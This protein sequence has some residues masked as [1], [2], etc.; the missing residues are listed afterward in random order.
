M[1]TFQRFGVG[2]GSTI[3]LAI[4]AIIYWEV[5]MPIFD[6]VA[7]DGIF[8]WVAVWID[9]IVPVLIVMLLLTVWLWVLAGGVQEE[10]T[11]RRRR[12]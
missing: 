11:A 2:F 6:M 9:R 10:R 12:I 4:G 1:R 8:S 7:D 3:A 5:F